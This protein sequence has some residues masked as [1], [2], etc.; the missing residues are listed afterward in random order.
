MDTLNHAIR[1]FGRD[2]ESG[3]PEE[4]LEA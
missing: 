2:M 4:N 1:G 3:C